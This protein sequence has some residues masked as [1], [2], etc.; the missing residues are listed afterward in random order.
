MQ[1]GSCPSCKLILINKHKDNITFD[2]F[3]N[4]LQ[5]HPKKAISTEKKVYKIKHKVAS[6]LK[7]FVL[8]HKTCHFKITKKASY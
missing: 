2:I 8:L 7:D 1:K 6:I 5:T 4:S 3:G